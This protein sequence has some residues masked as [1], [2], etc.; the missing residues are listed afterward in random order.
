[1]TADTGMPA[2]LDAEGKQLYLASE[3]AQF[4]ASIAQSQQATSAAKT[5]TLQGM[6]PTL[7]ADAPTGQVTLSVSAGA[8]GPWRAHQVIDTI[9]LK[10]AKRVRDQLQS[11]DKPRVLVVADPAVLDGD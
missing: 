8:F 10:V 11:I 9:A 6:L 7:P 1:M 3:K 2:G 5:A 4:V